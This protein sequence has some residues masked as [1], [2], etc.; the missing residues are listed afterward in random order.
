[1]RARIGI[2][3]GLYWHGFVQLIEVI[4]LVSALGA[5]GSL[6]TLL[7][8][9]TKYARLAFGRLLGGDRAPRRHPSM[10]LCTCHTH[11]RH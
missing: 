2:A 11:Q 10:M 1:M 6:P 3:M 9:L 7:S 4:A 5:I 8:A